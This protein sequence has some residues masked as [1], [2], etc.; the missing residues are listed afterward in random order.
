MI[1]ERFGTPKYTKSKELQ[2]N[3]WPNYSVLLKYYLNTVIIKSIL[4][5]GV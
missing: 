2:K 1:Q 3:S 5:I 4:L